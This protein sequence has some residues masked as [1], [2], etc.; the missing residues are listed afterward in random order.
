MWFKNI[1]VLSLMAASV[2]VGNDQTQCRTI[3]F[4]RIDDES[5]LER[6]K[7][8]CEITQSLAIFTTGVR[9]ITFPQLKRVG[10][11]NIESN[12]LEAIAFPKLESARDIYL[13]GSDLKVAEFPKLN[14]VSARLVIQEKNLKFFNLPELRRVGRF[15]LYGCTSL[16]FVFAD[17]LYDVAS[18]RVENA[19]ALN[20]ASAEN[21]KKVTRVLS[22]EEQEYI[23]NAQ[24]EM[25]LFKR[26]LWENS[27]NQP[28][29]R[30][31]GHETHFDSFG[32][33]RNYY[34][35]YPYEYDRYYSFIGP[36][37]YTWM[38]VLP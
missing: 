3:E 10:L 1:F 38:Y 23:K 21:L 30:P 33:I 24:E 5:Q 35:W 31:T 18:L 17:K 29:I 11:V 27:L 13:S 36:W 2:S 14:T 25:R 6:L 37:G 26:K 15:I 19:P 9:E 7:D 34:A 20:R 28:P 16:E 8:V 4:A 22:A 12:G 32:M